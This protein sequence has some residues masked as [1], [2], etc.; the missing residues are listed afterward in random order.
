MSAPFLCGTS[1]HRKEH[2]MAD[3][4]FETFIARERDRLSSERE[5]IFTQ[6]HE[7][8]TKLSAINREFAAIEA[9]EAAKKGR[10]PSARATGTRRATRGGSKRDQLMQVIRSA[11]GLTRGEILEKL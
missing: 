5:A 10:A 6:Q 11:A 4:T 9:Y 1:L 2:Q 3:E 8:E 7:L